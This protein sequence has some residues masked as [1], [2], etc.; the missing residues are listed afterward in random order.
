MIDP[1]IPLSDL[2]RHLEGSIRLTTILD[3]GHKFGLPLPAEDELGLRPYVQVTVPQTSVMQFIANF[4]WPMRILVNN[5]VCHR[6]AFEAVEDA[7]REGIDYL[8]LRFSPWF[9]AEA[10]ALDPI[11]IVEAVCDG[12]EAASRSFDVRVNLTGILSRTYGPEIA[13]RELH[14]L[15][16]QHERIQALDLA[17]D[18]ANWPGELFVDHFRKARD[19]GWHITVH[20][21][22]SVGPQSIWQAVQGLGAERIGHAVHALEDEAL[23]DYMLENQIGVE[24]NLTSNVQTS[25]VASYAEHPMRRFL[26]RG[27]RAALAS[28]DPGI[29]GIDL[30]YEYQVAAPAAGLTREQIRQAQLNSLEISFLSPP[31]K[32]DLWAKKSVNQETGG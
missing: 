21:G 12:T 32:V 17:G 19:V 2:H 22:E 16:S 28:D 18:E 13:Y 24:A 30:P 29:S 26:E 14:A 23:L 9:M 10:H 20:A 4:E 1:T 11:G 5:D 3:V 7:H 27:L 6:V 15:L 25:T 8:E 31:E